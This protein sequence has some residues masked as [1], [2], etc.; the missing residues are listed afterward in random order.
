MKI[1]RLKL[2]CVRL[3]NYRE[4]LILLQFKVS[5]LK[6]KEISYKKEGNPEL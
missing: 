1:N 2:D 4:D 3:F 6:M 5:E